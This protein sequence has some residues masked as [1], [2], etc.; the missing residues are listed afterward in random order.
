MEGNIHRLST[1]HHPVLESPHACEME[2]PHDRQRRF[3]GR[4][5]KSPSFESQDQLFYRNFHW[6]PYPRRKEGFMLSL[7][8]DASGFK[9]TAA[10]L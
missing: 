1:S 9:V 4:R 7:D 5:Q 8:T 2:R 10:L 3:C 6:R